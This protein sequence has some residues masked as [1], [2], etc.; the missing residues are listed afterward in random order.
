MRS[1]AATRTPLTV[2][3]GFLGAGKTTLVNALL[4]QADGLRIAV[5]VNDFGAVNI[6]AALIGSVAGDTIALTNGCICCAIGDDF[7]AGLAA[8]L[9]RDPP[10]G[11][12]LIECSGV[13]DP[14][15]IAAMAQVDPALSLA[16]VVI[17]VD[18]TGIAARLA[19]PLL[20][21]TVRRQLRPADLLVLTRTDLAPDTAAVEA[22]LR[23]LANR[24]A[25]MRALH[26]NLP[27]AAVL[28]ELHDGARIEAV[29]ARHAGDFATVTLVPSYPVD[30]TRLRGVLDTA[31]EGLLRAKGILP[32][33]DGTRILVQRVGRRLDL[34]P[35]DRAGPDALVLIGTGTAPWDTAD[36]LAPLGLRAR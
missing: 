33:T 13:A 4:R 16:G 29:P 27:I 24:A 19:D 14:A 7:A 34:L 35:H 8:V 11:H 5:L 17:A 26:G 9:E 32:V 20:A 18:V 12:I 22:L 25:M 28:G 10:P 36:L 23:P 1:S 3:G 30:L 2:L 21:D 6:D 15:G 31:P